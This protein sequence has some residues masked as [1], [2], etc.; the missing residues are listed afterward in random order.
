[1]GYLSM[2][3]LAPPLHEQ[4]RASKKACAPYQR[5]ADAITRL[6]LRRLITEAQAH[7]A[8]MKLVRALDSD[9]DVTA[10]V[11][12]AADKLSRALG[13]AAGRERSATPSEGRSDV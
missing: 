5:D 1:M 11:R 7:A 13:S 12:R 8:R 10:S 9:K 3:A 2:G 6:S 4:I